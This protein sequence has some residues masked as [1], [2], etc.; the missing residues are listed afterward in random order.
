MSWDNGTNPL[1]YNW[2]KIELRY[3][4]GAS[5]S[6]DKTTPTKVG[7]DTLHF[8]GRSILDAEIES[9]LTVTTYLHS[10]CDQSVISRAFLTD[11][12]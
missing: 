12:L 7:N 1:M 6:G 11:C 10:I 9:I 5:V 3:C 8:R 4:D 2:N